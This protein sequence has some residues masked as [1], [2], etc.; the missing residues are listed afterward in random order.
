MSSFSSKSS[1]DSIPLFAA[2]VCAFLGCLSG[3]CATVG[4]TTVDIAR[5][6]DANVER[7]GGPYYVIDEVGAQKADGSVRKS[8]LLHEVCQKRYPGLFSRGREAVPL[9]VRRHAY[10]VKS[11][12]R[13]FH[14]WYLLDG[15]TIC[16]WPQMRPLTDV[17]AD[18]TEIL[19][20][21]GKTLAKISFESRESEYLH[22]P[23]TLPFNSVL[24]PKS[25]GWGEPTFDNEHPMASISDAR[26]CAFADAIVA[27][28]ESLGPDGRDALQSNMDALAMYYRL[29]PYVIG[30]DIPGLQGKIVHEAPIV[31]PTAD[32]RLPELVSFE[33]D[34]GKRMGKLVSDFNR[35]DALFAQQWTIQ[36]LLLKK[37]RES[38]ALPGERA[39]LVKTESLSASG[40]YTIIFAVVE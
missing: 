39:V 3:G 26:F 7:L 14:W 38:V 11:E 27:G 31:R 13:S 36:Q 40:L 30:G 9:L 23:L 5:T 6:E 10:V 12:R 29:R 19:G 35:C 22:T 32:G 17:I 15:L 2:A 28:L 25:E 18:S 1:K 37:L 8:E 20:D 4:R 16:L 34:S 21:G 24:F 33:Y